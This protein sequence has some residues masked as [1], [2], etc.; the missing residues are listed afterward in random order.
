MTDEASDIID[1]YPEK[2]KIDLNGKRYAWQGNIYLLL[3]P[4][5]IVLH[6]LKYTFFNDL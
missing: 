2:F 3:Y 1:F 5:Y 6:I 4:L